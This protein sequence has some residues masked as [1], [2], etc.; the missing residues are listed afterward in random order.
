MKYNRGGKS[1]CVGDIG[2]MKV[3]R[4]MIL[5][6]GERLRNPRIR[7]NVRL[8]GLRQ[9]TS[10]YLDATL[11]AFA[12]PLRWFYPNFPTY[13]QEGVTTA[14]TIPTMTAPVSEQDQQAVSNLGIGHVN[15]AFAKWFIQMPL[16]VHNEWFRWLEDTRFSTTTPLYTDIAGPT[17]HGPI[18][19]NLTSM[20]S[21]M[22]ASPT[23][24]AD[25][26]DVPS[27]TV[28]DV[29]T[30]VQY[31]ARFKQAAE[32][33]WT[34]QNR[35]QPFMKNI[36]GAAGS[37]EIDQIPTRLRSGARLSVQPRDMYASDAAG[38]GE[39]MSISNF[40]V[41]HT[42]SDYVAKEHEIICFVQLMR[43]A[44]IM[45]DGLAPG[46]YPDVT[47]YSY[48]QGDPD[49]IAAKAPEAISSQEIDA[50]GDATIIGY[51]PAGWQLREGH[52]HSDKTVR[53]VLNF[54]LLDG[55][56]LTAAGYRDASKINN[57]F[58]ST[59]LRHWFADLNFSLE[60]ESRIKP[61]G[62]SI[63][64]GSAKGSGPSGNQPTGGYLI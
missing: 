2:C 44:P 57:A 46:V 54:P 7:G 38:L 34:T 17:G 45:Q 37:V 43:F 53:D 21:R 59:A 29:R 36:Y 14:E 58:R 10:V 62:H 64:A 26:S 16:K 35:Y 40:N 19:V 60:V 51:G 6:P 11:E 1:L 52:S 9:Q 4:Q 20:A 47:P 55:Q 39:I 33:D 15:R 8:S 12:A 63:V 50:G 42:W 5:Y 49:I 23:I 30:L 25:E 28:M 41:D 31:Q 56:L 24:H 3:L 18:C 61:A 48:F 27:A 32:T 22:H 13:L